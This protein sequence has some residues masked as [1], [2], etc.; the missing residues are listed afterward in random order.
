MMASYFL[1]GQESK[2]AGGVDFA[3]NV[4]VIAPDGSVQVC[5]VHAHGGYLDPSMESYDFDDSLCFMDAVSDLDH[6]VP[7]PETTNLATEQRLS[8]EGSAMQRW[9][10]DDNSND[11]YNSIPSEGSWS[12]SGSTSGGEFGREGRREGLLHTVYDNVKTS[13]RDR[14]DDESGHGSEARLAAQPKTTAQVTALSVGRAKAAVRRATTGHGSGDAGAVTTTRATGHAGVGEHTT[15]PNTF[16]DRI[17]SAFRNQTEDQTGRG[18]SSSSA[19][20]ATPSNAQTTLLL[21]SPANATTRMTPPGSGASAAAAAGEVG[22]E[23]TMHDTLH[24]TIQTAL[25]EHT[26]NQTSSHARAAQPTQ[27]TPTPAALSRVQTNATVQLSSPA[28][29]CVLY[30]NECRSSPR[31]CSHLL[32]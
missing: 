3:S 1:T 20:M 5:P 2:P 32:S 22:R 24:N 23:S 13:F 11:G 26:E 30:T 8:T 25:E 15:T 31:A 18:G 6:G 14:Q 28:S 17:K 27:S 9:N 7:P 12:W 16:Y 19:R 21:Q 4:Q 10:L 29:A